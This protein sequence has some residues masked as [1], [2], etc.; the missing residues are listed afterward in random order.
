[1]EHYGL[2]HM[3]DLGAGFQ[4]EEKYRLAVKFWKLAL[5]VVTGWLASLFLKT[6]KPS[7]PAPHTI[8]SHCTGFPSFGIQ[9]PI[10]SVGI[11]LL[12]TLFYI[13]DFKTII[14]LC[15]KNVQ[16]NL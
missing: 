13:G 3:G 11:K 12:R 1:M 10:F 16:R 9:A 2:L 14:T 4:W 7:P 8:H 6:K 15:V 5:G